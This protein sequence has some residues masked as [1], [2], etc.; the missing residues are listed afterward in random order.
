MTRKEHPGSHP[1]AGSW[2]RVAIVGA[3]TLKG[4]EL[5]DVLMERNFPAAETRLLD[6]D[7]SLG[8]LDAL[9]DEATFI[10]AVR[11]G[12]FEG[13][14]LVFFASEENFTRKNWTLAKNAGS[15]IVDLSCAL[16]GEAG[17]AVRAPWVEREL[18]RDLGVRPPAELESGPVIAAHPAAV[19]LALLLLRVQRA[20][21]IRCAVGTVFEPASE[22][23]RRGMDELHEQTVNLLSFHEMPKEVFDSQVAFNMIARYGEKSLPTLESVERRI[24]SHLG[25]ITHERV[26]MPALVVVQAPIFHAHAFSVYIELEKPIAIEAFRETIA[27]EHVTVAELPEDSPS[28]VNAAGQDTVLVSAHRDAQHENGFWI[29]AAADNLRVAAITAVDCAAALARMRSKG[30]V[31]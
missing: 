1:P 13:L 21:A 22:H 2:Y 8:Q 24:V 9:G 3:A 19:V 31:H 18:A 17:S 7:E 11:P 26:P 25:Q 10:Q 5:K 16:E 23:G 6:D 30:T 4:K 27:G 28:N 12:Q 29:W 14:D 15:M 20:S